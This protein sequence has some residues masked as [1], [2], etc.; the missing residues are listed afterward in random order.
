MNDI[1]FPS[2]VE[3]NIMGWLNIEEKMEFIVQKII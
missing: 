2:Q 3:E 1:F